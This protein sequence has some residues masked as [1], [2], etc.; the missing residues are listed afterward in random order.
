M[1]GHTDLACKDM[2][3]LGCWAIWSP[4]QLLSLCSKAGMYRQ[5]HLYS[6]VSRPGPPTRV[7]W[8]SFLFISALSP[9]NLI[10][11]LCGFIK[12]VFRPYFHYQGSLWTFSA[13]E[14]TV[15]KNNDYIHMS[16]SSRVQRS[17]S[18]GLPLNLFSP[19]SEFLW[20]L[21]LLDPKHVSIP[22]LFLLLGLFLIIDD[23][24][25]LFIPH[26]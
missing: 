9:N 5:I 15:W 7:Y 8:R 18:L 10:I 21:T 22:D 25:R 26:F 2:T 13:E 19:K 1:R 17:N 14:D 11:W 20:A 3:A 24:H 12:T 6:P 16:S 4:W 23:I